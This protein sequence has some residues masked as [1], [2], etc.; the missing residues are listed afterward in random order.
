MVQ[1]FSF[2]SITLAPGTIVKTV[3]DGWCKRGWGMHGC[4]L[5]CTRTEIYMRFFCCFGPCPCQSCFHMYCFSFPE[6]GPGPGWLHSIVEVNM[7]NVLALC[8]VGHILGT[9]KFLHISWMSTCRFGPN[10]ACFRENVTRRSSY[11]A[12]ICALPAS[13]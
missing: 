5:P 8:K 4:D 2:C 10:G 12:S 3:Q 9:C 13:I 6:F 11:E 1:G 7:K